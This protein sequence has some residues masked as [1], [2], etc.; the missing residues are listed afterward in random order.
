MAAPDGSAVRCGRAKPDGLNRPARLGSLR[1]DDRPGSRQRA[2][3]PR[4]EKVGFRPVGKL[5]QYQ[6]F[7]DGTW[8][9]SI[10]MELLAEDITEDRAEV[11]AERP[12]PA[13][14]G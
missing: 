4:Y 5:R 9:D 7:P 1:H 2:R 12:A 8:H 11:V 6:R 3:D 14:S 13:R 10:L